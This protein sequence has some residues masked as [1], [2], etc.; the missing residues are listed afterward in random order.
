MQEAPQNEQ[1][2]GRTSSSSVDLLK[3]FVYQSNRNKG[4]SLSDA[5]DALGEQRRV[6]RQTGR[7]AGRLVGGRTGSTST[8]VC[9]IPKASD[10]NQS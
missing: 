10:T 3:E 6:D 2:G 1:L 5:M 9:I 8:K 4:A 7:Q